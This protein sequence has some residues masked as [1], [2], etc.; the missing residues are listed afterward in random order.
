LTRGLAITIALLLCAASGL[1]AKQLGFRIAT[2]PYT[3]RFPRDHFAHDDYRSEWW[4]FTGHLQT[5][6][7]RRF[8]YEL[9]FFR[10]GIQPESPHWAKSQSKWYAYQ[11]YPAHF[12]ITDIAS[13]QFVFFETLARDALGQG[14][15]SNRRL[16]VRAND[17]TLTGTSDTRPVLHLR[18]RAGG[19]ELN[20]TMHSA[21]PPAINGIGGIS[22][23]GPCSSCASHYYSF[24]RLTTAG[25][26]VRHGVRYT[27]SGISWMDHEFGSDELSANQAGWD[28]FSI[29]LNDGRELMLYRLRQKDGSTT[30]QSSGSFVSRNGSVQYLP[31][32]QFSIAATGSWRSPQTNALY[33]SGWRIRVAPLQRVLQLIPVMRD[34]ELAST[35]SPAY[36]EGD[37]DVRDARTGALLGAGYVE[38]TGYAAPLRY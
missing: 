37:V 4:Y 13:D 21:K 34:Q 1:C 14:F 6:N 5:A 30:P 12:A 10:I 33:P 38:L 28:W 17:W 25:T 20:L 31:L 29:Q 7:G 36:W 26:L 3:Y 8:G 11:L 32:S 2:S 23:K 9:T 18:A 15:A 16:E 22:R 19:N 35:D 24:T 27:V